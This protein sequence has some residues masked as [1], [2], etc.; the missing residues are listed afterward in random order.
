MQLMGV[1][2]LMITELHI[3][4]TKSEQCTLDLPHAFNDG[5]RCCRYPED[6]QGQP[7]GFTSSTC[8][9]SLHAPCRKERCISNGK[10]ETIIFD[11]III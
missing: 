2:I 7:L 9:Y 5:K 11:K 3:T 8:K 10:S 1:F 6:M 4:G